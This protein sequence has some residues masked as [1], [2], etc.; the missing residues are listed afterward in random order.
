MKK[1]WLVLIFAALGL[2]WPSPT[3]GSSISSGDDNLAYKEAPNWYSS[4]DPGNAYSLSDEGAQAEHGGKHGLWIADF[5]DKER[6]TSLDIPPGSWAWLQLVPAVSGELSLYCQYPT[7][8]TDLLL[9]GQVKSGHGYSAWYHSEAEGEYQVWYTVDGGSKS[10]LVQFNVQ[11][12]YDYDLAGAPLTMASGS[13]APSPIM[14][15]SSYASAPAES[16][17]I[18]FS[19]GGA[20]DIGNFRE[21]IKNGYLPLPTDITY[22][23]LFY[24][25]YFDTGQAAECKKLFCPSYSYAVSGDPFSKEP[26]Y[27]LTVGLNSG[28]TD[29][30]RKKLNLVVVLDNSGS[31]GESFNQYYYDRFG[32]QVNLRDTDE[33]GKKKMEIA[34]QAVADLLGHLN[35]D[36]R[37]GV[38]I[39]SDNALIVDPLTK[40]GDKD[41]PRLKEHIQK[42][43][44]DGS[45][46]MQSGM[47]RGAR[48][49][50]RYLDADPSEYENRMIF[51]TDA[52]PN[53][54][55]TGEDD[56]SQALL[57]NSGKRV[58]TTFI[59]IGVDFN[60]ELAEGITKAKGANYYSV[61][62]SSEFKE[63]MDDEFDYMVTPLVFDLKL[64][65][66][67]PGY[68]IE[69]VYGS[70]EADEA[71]GELMKV[72]TLFPSKAEEGRVKGGVVLVKLKKTSSKS[73]ADQNSMR[74]KVA[75]QD[76][77]G[78]PDSD[79]S[80]VDL[81]GKEPDFYQNTGIRKAVLLTRYA[82]LLKDWAIDEREAQSK[83]GKNVLPTVTLERG[84]VVPVELGEWERQSMPL[85]VSEPYRK[86]FGL[87][88]TYFE[89]ESRAIGDDKLQ[90]EQELLE[91]LS[92]F[93]G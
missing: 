54:G 32:N 16:P 41:I 51:L 80:E 9:T 37:F 39:F 53:V 59:G 52:M 3:W 43:T 60:T 21:N 5:G 28:I 88:G 70:P 76:R 25:Y 34:D 2:S 77:N 24:D 87:F 90:Q 63:R 27:Y 36:D 7:G 79:E 72:N 67:A 48:L 57:D 1:I 83:A 12:Q 84:I 4:N 42:I 64:S 18:G 69:K 62:S 73:R 44:E 66:D 61:H 85:V 47:E 15:R 75:Y 8:S 65:L 26:Q 30:Q 20:K 29:F 35:A 22:E 92:D 13:V 74:L 19:T 86:L 89:S 82:D 78:V 38:V 6:R 23:G 31:M 33:S 14:A 50:S 68:E 11:E 46:N 17:G 56:L 49:F 55:Q 40:V 58:Y 71:T 45:T 91:K 93:Q 81:Q 10:N